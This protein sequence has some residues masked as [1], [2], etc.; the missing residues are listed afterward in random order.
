MKNLMK[1]LLKAQ[2]EMGAATKGADNPFFRSK[3]ADYGAVLEAVKD[4]LNNN[5][6]VVLQ[7]HVFQDGRNFVQTVLVHAESG[8]TFSSMT[9][10]VCKEANN[11]QMLGSAITYARRYGLQSLLSLPVE[12]DDGNAGSGKTYASQTKTA[13]KVEPKKETKQ[14]KIAKVDAVIAQVPQQEIKK[15]EPKAKPAVAAVLEAGW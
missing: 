14:E 13:P 6:I 2:Q 1:A 8:E 4:P 9:E 11:P 7:P 15:E 10:V 5:G 3:Y 12:D